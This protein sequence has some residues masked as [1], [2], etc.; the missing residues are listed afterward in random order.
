[1][2]QGDDKNKEGILLGQIMKVSTDE[3]LNLLLLS[4]GIAQHIAIPFVTYIH[5]KY[6]KY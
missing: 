2:S 3:P 1:M 5:W 4:R 6:E